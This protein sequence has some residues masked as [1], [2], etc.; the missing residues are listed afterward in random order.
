VTD[1]LVVTEPSGTTEHSPITLSASCYQPLQITT[2]SPLPQGTV[3][4]PYSVTIQATGGDGKYAW[5]ASNLPEGL[6]INSTSGL[7]SGT[8]AIE[9]TFMAVVT[10]SDS[11][12]SALQPAM[13][14]FSLTITVQSY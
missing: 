10:V 4:F 11:D 8:P 12:Q 6:S 5:S 9:G 14:T 3:S 13:A 7:I 1:T 2:K